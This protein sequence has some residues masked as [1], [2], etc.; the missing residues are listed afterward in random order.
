MVLPQSCSIWPSVTGPESQNPANTAGHPL[1]GDAFADFLL[2]Y[3]ASV[4]RA[5]PAENFGGQRWYHQYLVQ[6]DIR[7]SDKL[8][9]SAGLRYEYS[10]WMNG[11]RGQLGT[12]DPTE[13]KPII[14]ESNTDQVDLS[15]QLVAPIACQYFGKYIQTTAAKILPRSGQP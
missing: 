5:Y 13:A 9:V 12:F 6:D 7:V 4:A 2:G 15:S 1:G 8:T 14:I 3:P 11:Y 10:P